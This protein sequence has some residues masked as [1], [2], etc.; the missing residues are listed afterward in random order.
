MASLFT[1]PP[2]PPKPKPVDDK[3]AAEATAEAL[4]RR[5]AASGY[6]STI[7]SQMTQGSTLKP[8]LGG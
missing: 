6:R 3:A 1:S 5:K 7:L 4:R 2:K 8:T